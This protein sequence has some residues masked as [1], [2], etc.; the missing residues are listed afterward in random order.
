MGP[1]SIRTMLRDVHDRISIEHTTLDHPNIARRWSS[2]NCVCNPHPQSARRGYSVSFYSMV[3][4]RRAKKRHQCWPFASV[5]TLAGRVHPLREISVPINCR[6]RAISLK[7][8]V[9]S[10]QFVS[11]QSDGECNR[12]ISPV[13]SPTFGRHLRKCS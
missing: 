12:D 2:N 4:R 9:L 10:I 7:F 13:I 1:R 11:D 5:I 3:H 8:R 6:H